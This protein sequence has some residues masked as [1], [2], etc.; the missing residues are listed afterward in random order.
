MQT[1]R[2]YSVWSKHSS[3]YFYPLFQTGSTALFFASQQGHN[4]IVKLL[5]EFGAST[6]C[7][8]K[9]R[10]IT[11]AVC[12]TLVVWF[13]PCHSAKGQHLCAVAFGYNC[14]EPFFCFFCVCVCLWQDGGT[15][16]TAASQHGHSKVVDTLLKNGANVHDQLNVRRPSTSLRPAWEIRVK[17]NLVCRVSADCWVRQMVK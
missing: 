8:T 2:K 5:F 4:E 6:E 9:V 14:D 3:V 16:L 7:R 13:W 15:A 11:W 1:K 10:V 17:L 12:R